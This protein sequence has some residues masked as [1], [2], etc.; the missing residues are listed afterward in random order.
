MNR[1]MCKDSHLVSRLFPPPP[2]PHTVL[3]LARDAWSIVKHRRQATNEYTLLPSP[4]YVLS[5]APL[6]PRPYI[7]QNMK[8]VWERPARPAQEV[9]ASLIQ[10]LHSIVDADF[11]AATT[12]VTPEGGATASSEPSALHGGPSPTGSKAV[13]DSVAFHD[14]CRLTEELQGLPPPEMVDVLPGQKTFTEG[15]LKV[16]WCFFR[17]ALGWPSHECLCLP[18]WLA[19]DEATFSPSFCLFV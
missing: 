9:I 13:A 17:Y 2:H 14:W 11:P 8:Q 12:V 18:V 6:P 7:P 1:V 3:R 10:A 16:G 5:R 15:C 19:A 4:C